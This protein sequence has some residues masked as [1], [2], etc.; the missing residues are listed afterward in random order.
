M[1]SETGLTLVHIKFLGFLFAP[2]SGHKDYGAR[3]KSKILIY[4]QINKM[5]TKGEGTPLQA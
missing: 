2:L 4:R 3:A 5:P 1:I